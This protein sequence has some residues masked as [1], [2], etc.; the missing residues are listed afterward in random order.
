MQGPVGL[1]LA[2]LSRHG[3]ELDRRWN[4]CTRGHVRF[5][6]LAVPIQTLAPQIIALGRKGRQARVEQRRPMTAGNGELA[7]WAIRAPPSTWD[8]PR[9]RILRRVQSLGV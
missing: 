9:A 2:S 6:L 4:V 5:N 1:L 7:E 8:A 3:V